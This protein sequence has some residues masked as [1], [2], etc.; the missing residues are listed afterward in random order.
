[1]GRRRKLKPRL[2]PVWM[3]WLRDKMADWLDSRTDLVYKRP[4]SDYEDVLQEAWSRGDSLRH[5]PMWFV[6]RDMTTLALHTALYEEPPDVD[7]PSSTGFVA[8]DGGVDFECAPGGA[9]VHV[10]AVRWIIQFDG[11]CDRHVGVAL[12]TDDKG[13]RESLRCPLPLAPVPDTLLGE[14]NEGVLGTI[15]DMLRAVWALSAEPT[16]CEVRAPRRPSAV[17]PLPPR[18][19]ERAISDVRMVVLR[20]QR[21]SAPSEGAGHG[22][23]HGYSH[24]FIVRGFWRN[25]A[26]GKNHGLRRRQWI[27]P[28]IKGP[29]DKPLVA[30]ET[31]RIWR[32]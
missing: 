23:R 20:E 11:Q 9:P 32:R 13:V 7:A 17:E 22:S 15:G 16:V 2:S 6:S 8:F 29:A 27:P 14:V 31:V 24:R 5:S 18:M 26:Y 28:F 12:Y 1:M 19:V 3:P 4:S 21:A 25:Q 10:V 30:K